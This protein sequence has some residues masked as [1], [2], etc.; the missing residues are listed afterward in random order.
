MIA[1]PVPRH[2]HFRHMIM[3]HGWVDLE[4]FR[5]NPDDS[6]LDAVLKTSPQ[7]AF[8]V[9]I[10]SDRDNKPGQRLVVKKKAG[11]RLGKGDIAAVAERIGWMFRLDEDFTPFQKTCGRTKGLTWVRRYGLGPF[12]RNSDLFEEFVK[13]LFTTNVSWAGT[14]MMNRLFIEHLGRPVN[15]PPK[16]RGSVRAKKLRAF[17][18]A[19]AVARVSEAYLREKVR[20]GYRAPYL[21]EFAQNV[22]SG[23]LRLDAFADRSIP[24]DDLA[25]SLSSIKGFGPYAVSALFLTLGRYDRLILDSWTRKKA[26]E[27]HF[28]TGKAADRSLRRVYDKWGSWQTLACWFEC[29]YD[30]WFKDELRKK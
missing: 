24:P 11:P 7:K 19:D 16:G 5:W 6:S 3:S 1:I 9:T 2:F 15:G 17:P 25:K 27:R 22:A 14:R 20:V 10:T 26:A 30:T 29:A 23:A 18:D 28:K 21:I 4:P 8:A 13:V 12:L